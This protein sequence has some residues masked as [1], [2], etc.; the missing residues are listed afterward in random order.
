MGDGASLERLLFQ[1]A[2]LLALEHSL[3]I[4]LLED[5]LAAGVSGHMLLL[6][7]G[8]FVVR[9]QIVDPHRL[10]DLPFGGPTGRILV[11]GERVF[12]ELGVGLRHY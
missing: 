2:L 7:C 6:I 1:K 9:G 5:L 12:L 10:E 11:G 3:D 8:C 4:L